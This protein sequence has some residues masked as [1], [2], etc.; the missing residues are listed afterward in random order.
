MCARS[1]LGRTHRDET[2]RRNRCQHAQQRR[3]R[4]LRRHLLEP[5]RARSRHRPVHGFHHIWAFDR[6]DR[7]R[8]PG[9]HLMEM[10]VL[11]H[12]DPGRS[13]LAASAAHARDLRARRAQE[14]SPSPAQARPN[15]PGTHRA[16]PARRL[17]DGSRD[18]DAARTHV[19]LRVH[20]AVQLPVHRAH[21]RYILQ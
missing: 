7:K 13:D 6:A 19:P 21:I 11:A 8:L 14:E 4:H 5:T 17:P 12:V 15:H 9:S 18:P 16:R 1:H 2:A 20:R 3:R 10:G